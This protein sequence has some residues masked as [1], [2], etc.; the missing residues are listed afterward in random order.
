MSLALI[1]AEAIL[2]VVAVVAQMIERCG[3]GCTMVAQMIERCGDGCTMV[4]QMIERC[5]NGCRV[6]AQMWLHT[7]QMADELVERWSSSAQSEKQ[8]LH[9]HFHALRDALDTRFVFISYF[10]PPT[11]RQPTRT[12]AQAHHL[13][14]WRVDGLFMV[15]NSLGS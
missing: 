6:V 14:F 1:H 7:V 3:D 4:A 5:G 8:I 15:V 10:I 11:S 12:A 2:S 13:F 9:A